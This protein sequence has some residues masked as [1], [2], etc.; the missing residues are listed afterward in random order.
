MLPECDSCHIAAALRV[1]A[2]IVEHS[3]EAVLVTDAANRIVAANPELTRLTGY[4]AEELLGHDPRIFTS[5]ETP[6]ETFREMWDALNQQGRW[7]GELRDRR[8]DGT[9][10]PKWVRIT[11]LRDSGITSGYIA[12]FTDIG[13]RKFDEARLRHLAFNDSLT[14]LL[15]R[16]GLKIQLDRAIT[17][18][19]APL[20]VLL[21][22][23]EHLKDINKTLGHAVGDQ[24]LVAVA[25]RLSACVPDTSIF[26]TLGGGEFVIVLTGPQ[27]SAAARTLANG[28]LGA[29]GDFHMIDGRKVHT[30]ACIGAALFPAD[31]ADAATLLQ[32]AATAMYAVREKG[33][34]NVQFFDTAMEMR[35][36]ARLE[37]EADLR[38]ALEAGQLSLHYQPQ[39]TAADGRI[40]GF[41]ALLRW[42]HPL[43]GM[44]SPAEFIPVA[45]ESGLI[46]PIG[47]WVLDTAC[48]QLAAWRVDGVKGL[49]MAVNLSARQLHAADL[50]LQVQALLD[51]HGILP[52]E[53][54]IEVTES[55]AMSDPEQGIERLRALRALGITLAIDDF[56]TGYSSLAYLKLLPIHVLKIDRA[57]VRDV[58]T[59]A[60]DT[61]ICAATVALAH[62]L[63]LKV[64]AEGIETEAQRHVLIGQGCD[65]LQGYLFGWPAPAEA[66]PEHLK[67][68]MNN[69]HHTEAAQ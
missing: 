45:E 16:H 25:E 61:A 34:A 33:R 9:T 50:V 14:G 31:G 17:A 20:A 54:E 26:A 10:F 18:E 1:H 65:Y 59:N 64:V 38:G 15:N 8:K 42:R 32:H 52:G 27:D 60:N 3:G 66:W 2:S 22:G 5:G 58:E 30:D 35:A 11:A 28:M 23:L 47:A 36:L 41:E 44:V 57:F 40:C 24:L 29:L 51:R 48:R 55:V 69:P 63:G 12:S 6:P 37:L 53:L 4:A 39:V 56:G 19:G 62:T 68:L 21:L 7:E 13:K 49:R 67:Q 43:R 46:E